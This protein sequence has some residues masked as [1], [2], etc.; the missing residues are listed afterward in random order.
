MINIRE[1][2]GIYVPQKNQLYS[3]YLYNYNQIFITTAEFNGLSSAAY[4]N[5]IVHLEQKILVKI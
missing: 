3:N 2:R 4:G 5:G 1:I